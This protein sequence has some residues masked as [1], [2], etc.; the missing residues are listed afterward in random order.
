VQVAR[1]PVAG[2]RPTVARSRTAVRDRAPAAP[3]VQA[4]PPGPAVRVGV[5]RA[6]PP[7]VARRART[8]VHL[9]E[10]ASP[11]HSVPTG[12]PMSGV[13]MSDVP[14]SSRDP[15]GSAPGSGVRMSGVP[16]A[17]ALLKPVPATPARAVRRTNA[18]PVRHLVRVPGT[19]CSRVPRAAHAGSTW[20]GVR[21]ARVVVVV[22]VRRRAGRRPHAVRRR[23]ELVAGLERTRPPNRCV[24]AGR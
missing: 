22:V 11:R 9:L 24:S 13:R 4:V 1:P 17:T 12:V 15:I 21:V 8:V 20:R 6:S 7:A 16:I 10:Q 18:R 23:A 5:V 3:A 2:R 19:D 14:I